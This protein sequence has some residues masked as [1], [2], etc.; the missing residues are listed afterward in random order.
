MN[1]QV[2]LLSRITLVA[3][4]CLLANAGFMLYQNHRQAE[5]SSQQMAEALQKQLEAQ[6]L[7]RKAG[8]GQANIFP[9]FEWWK[10]SGSQP[11]VC[12]DYT[13]SDQALSHSLCSGSKPLVTD[14]PTVF[15]MVYRQIFKPG[16]PEVR[17]IAT[18]DH[19][20]GTLTITPNP[21]QE[22]ANAWTHSLSL[23]TLSSVTIL[24]VC[25][26][27]YLSI[28]RTLQPATTIILGLAQMD[29][30]QFAYRLPEFE[31]SEWQRIAEAINQLASNQQHLLEERQ[32]LLVK[33]MTLQEEERRYLAQELHDELG[34]C[35]AAIN[36]VATS[37]QQ[38]ASQQCPILIEDAQHI[39][40]ITTHTLD[41]VRGML[42]RLRPPEFDALSLAISLNSLIADWN[43]RSFGKTNYALNMLGDSHLLSS[44]QAI[45]LFRIIQECLTNIAKHAQAT[46]VN[47]KL[48]I[49]P[50]Y[51]ALS[52]SDNGIATQLPFARCCG[53]GLVGMRERV[54]ALQGK[55]KLAIADP[56]GLIVAVS[57]PMPINAEQPS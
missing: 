34:Q 11:G 45:A 10:R 17:S 47:I 19:V 29:T 50:N 28:R 52:V 53:I 30:D 24:G 26:L 23:M 18:P 56:H 25:L 22:I 12:I 39:S 48:S 8:I 51:A 38:T 36:A 46:Q 43:E 35:L 7:L 41:W 9:D 27:V 42:G 31:L 40:R 5:Q 32:T 3:V 57:L 44:Q 2:H 14:W 16:Q 6:L 15:A 55:L 1:L 54:A 21:E 13:S 37:I 49:D 33:L 4:L 20:Y